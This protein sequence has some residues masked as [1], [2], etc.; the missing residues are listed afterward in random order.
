MVRLKWQRKLS[1][2]VNNPRLSSKKIIVMSG[3]EE[4]ILTFG[5]SL[6][7]A[8]NVLLHYFAAI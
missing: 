8:S 1:D 2:Y 4:G 7:E 3:H 5:K 6:A